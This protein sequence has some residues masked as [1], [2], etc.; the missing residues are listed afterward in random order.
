MVQ[1]KLYYQ[2]FNQIVKIHMN[3]TFRKNW[4]IQINTNSK[5]ILVKSKTYKYHFCYIINFINKNG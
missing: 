4:K 3:M 1:V 5:L 2:K